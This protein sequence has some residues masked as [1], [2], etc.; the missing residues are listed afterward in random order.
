M[1]QRL[2]IS[3]RLMLD[4]GVFTLGVAGLT[5]LSGYSAAITAQSLDRLG[6]Q[7]GLERLEHSLEDRVQEG[8]RAVWLALATGDPAQQAKANTAWD[9]ASHLLDEL[10]AAAGNPE[11]ARPLDA[12]QARLAE[13]VALA[14]TATTPQGA[15]APGDKAAAGG[16]MSAVAARFAETAGAWAADHRAGADAAI[17][18]AQRRLGRFLRMAL[19]FGAASVLAGL[20]LTALLTRTISRPIEAVTAAMRSLAAGDV[21]TPLPILAIGNEFGAMAAALQQFREHELENRRLV[22]EHAQRRDATT[23][24]RRAALRQM[25]DTIERE[26]GLAVE[27]VRKLTLEI[28]QISHAMADDAGR[29]G[30]TASEA[31]VAAS[32]SLAAAR[33]VAAAAAQLTESA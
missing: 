9:A 31:A 29:T 8:E 16:A 27:Q 12:L 26:T 3:S 2:K 28:T 19:G 7:T 22:E 14:A 18:E 4:F 33:I 10:R 25:A 17:S 21:A 32:Q 24:A 23:E 13:L 15:A 11:Q 20:G 6:Q 1:L 30:L 5:A